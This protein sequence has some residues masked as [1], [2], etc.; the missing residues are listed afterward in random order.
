VK[1]DDVKVTTTAA[2]QGIYEVLKSTTDIRPGRFKLVGVK[3]GAILKIHTIVDLEGRTGSLKLVYRVYNSGD[4]NF[5]VWTESSTTVPLQKLM[6]EQS[7][8]VAPA[9]G[10]NISVQAETEGDLFSGIY[11]LL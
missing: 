4:K 7:I 11:E 2:S 10:G 9:V 1:R 6:P 3:S 5:F 8:D